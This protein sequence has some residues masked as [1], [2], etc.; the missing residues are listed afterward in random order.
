MALHFPLIR[1]TSTTL[2]DSEVDF[3]EFLHGLQVM[4]SRD[5]EMRRQDLRDHRP[6]DRQGRQSS[7]GASPRVL[8]PGI[9][10]G[11]ERHVA[12]PPDK[13]PALEVIQSQFVLQFLVLLLDRPTLMRELDERLERRRRRQ[14]H[15]VRLDPRRGPEVAFE[16]HPDFG[17]EP[18]RPP[19][20]RRRRAQRRKVGGPRAIRAIAPRDPSPRLGGERGRDRGTASGGVSPVSWSRVGVPARPGLR[21]GTATDG[22]PRNTVSVD[23]TP[24]AYGSFR[25]CRVRRRVAL[26][27]NSASPSTAVT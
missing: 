3:R 16:E 18:T 26:S 14:R 1:S 8:Q 10:Q 23:D 12:V 4:R 2:L 25:R 19:L 15:E 17:G 21:A 6:D 9:C 22:V 27:P 20:V 5:E 13:R 24:S 7:A 11:G